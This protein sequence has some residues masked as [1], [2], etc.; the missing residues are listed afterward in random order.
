MGQAQGSGI[1]ASFIEMAVGLV[2]SGEVTE[3][4]AE[5]DGERP[6]MRVET[7]CVHHRL[8]RVRM[9]VN[10]RADVFVER[11]LGKHARDVEAELAWDRVMVKVRVR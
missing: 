10:A 1:W 3:D 6:F 8:E 9:G 5:A 11:E 2:G 4:E 7:Q